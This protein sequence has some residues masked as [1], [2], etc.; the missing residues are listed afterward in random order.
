MEEFVQLQASLVLNRIRTFQTFSIIY[1]IKYISSSF[2]E[3]ECKKEK[4]VC[5]SDNESMNP[6]KGENVVFTLISC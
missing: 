4:N 5:A 3:Y 6:E 2:S 1:R